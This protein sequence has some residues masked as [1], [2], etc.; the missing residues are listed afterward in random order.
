[1]SAE[2]QLRLGRYIAADRLEMLVE[3]AALEVGLGATEVLARQ[4][5]YLNGVVG[6]RVERLR[7]LERLAEF[8]LALEPL[9]AS[10]IVALDGGG[11]AEDQAPRTTVDDGGANVA[12]ADERERERRGPQTE[13]DAECEDPPPFVGVRPDLLGPTDR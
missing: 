13:A 3:H 12:T 4:R 1:M 7:R 6:W 9:L 5:K 2:A 11:P 10:L 8:R